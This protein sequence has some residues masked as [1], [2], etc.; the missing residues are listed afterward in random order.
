MTPNLSDPFVIFALLLIVVIVGAALFWLVRLFAQ[1]VRLIV[2]D[3]L[4]W[5]D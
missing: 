4:T 3:L 5:R 2:A 1:C